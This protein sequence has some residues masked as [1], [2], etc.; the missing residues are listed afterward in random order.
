MSLSEEIAATLPQEGDD[1]ETM[2]IKLS[3][4]VAALAQ[5]VQGMLL[6]QALADLPAVS[7]ERMEELRTAASPGPAAEPAQE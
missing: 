7:P 3:N 2:I 6:K 1:T 4:A 5:V